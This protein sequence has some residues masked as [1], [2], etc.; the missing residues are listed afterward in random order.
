MRKIRILSIDGGGIRGIIPAV[1][2][3]YIEEQLQKKTNNP[4]ARIS[5]YFDLIAGTSTGGILSCFYL[6]PNSSLK[7][8]LPSSKYEA[9]KALDFYLNDG[10]KIFNQSKRANWFGLRSLF[11]ATEYSPKRLESIF[12]KEFEYNRFSSLLKPCLI[13]SYNLKQKKAE[14]FFSRD[15]FKDFFVKDVARSTSAAPTYFPPAK[16]KELSSKKEMINIDGGVFANNPTMCAYAQS[17]ISE[18]EQTNPNPTAADMLIIS[19]G[20][21]AKQYELDKI[22][23]V[24]K[25]NVLNWAKVI[26]EIMMDGAVDTVHYQIDKMFSAF[27]NRLNYK[28]IDVPL[29]YRK[30]Y[31]SNMANAS[32]KNTDALLKAGNYALFDAKQ[33]K[34]NQLSL[35]NFIDLLIKNSPQEEVKNELNI[36]IKK[37]Q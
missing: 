31:D 16:I 29:K 32:N 25:W 33:E 1:V 11:N 6:T 34:P 18:F 8:N 10:I 27:G 17:R 35:D 13:T 3:K 15:K 37:E 9:E 20:T 22:K 5:D 21:G 30:T 23:T 24:N 19:I 36:E 4:L 28:R 7:N 12:D 26:P 2:V 14:F